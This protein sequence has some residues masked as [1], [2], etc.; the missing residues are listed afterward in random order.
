M[1]ISMRRDPSNVHHASGRRQPFFG[2]YIVAGSVVNNTLTSAAYFQGFQAFFLP[3][4]ATFGWSRTAISGAFS[5]RQ[6]ESG[7][8][9][10]VVGLLTDRWG[11]RVLII[12]GALLTGGGL[13]GLSQTRNLAMF[14][15]FFL[16]T[17]VGTAGS[18]HGVTWAVLI[19]R[20]FVKRRGRA[21]GI[22][23]IGPPLGGLFVVV[24][25]YLVLDF[26]WRPV[27]FG[28]GVVVA[29]VGVGLGWIA[30]PSPEQ[31]G[32]RPDGDDA[33]PALP[34]RRFNGSGEG[35]TAK[36]VLR[37]RDF[38]VITAFLTAAFVGTSA[39]QAHQVAY[40]VSTGLSGSAAALTVLL[41]ALASG[42]G[43]VGA[44]ALIDALDY[45]IVLA[46]MT[47]LLGASFVYLM[48]VPTT[49]IWL[50][51]PFALVYG[52]GWGSS[53]PIRPVVGGLLFGTRS[54]GAVV[55][56]MHFGSLAGGVVGPLVMGGIFDT[57]GTYDIAVVVLA[58]VSF[59]TMPLLLLLRPRA[60]LPVTLRRR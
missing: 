58:G 55:G 31:Y 8:M 27:L 33:T 36:E 38:W 57:T 14:Y 47:A 18:S 53:V 7:L 9:S 3:I 44:G 37:A 32:L 10:P 56:L 43:R 54:I 23:T 1:G 5:L 30:R 20:W 13:M 6:I 17:S 51:L 29:I 16:V 11:A 19:A 35:L 40:F 60:R 42:I 15:L 48:L 52:I 46:S 41:A 45:R 4:L 25:T 28:Y 49:T 34:S 21:M 39:F 50:A 2:W 26:G 24:N 59:S 22:A 12:V